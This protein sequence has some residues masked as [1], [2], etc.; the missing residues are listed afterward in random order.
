MKTGSDYLGRLRYPA[1][2]WSAAAGPLGDHGP[3]RGV[4][5]LIPTYTSTEGDRTACLRQCLDSV[6]TAPRPDHQPI[7]F[8]VVDNGLSP[9][10]ARQVAEML[11]GSGCAHRVVQAVSARSGRYTAAEAR[12]AGLAMLAELPDTSDLRQRHLLFLDDDTALEQHA[13]ARLTAV[14][15]AEQAAIA[16]C[17]RVVPVADLAAWRAAHVKGRHCAGE[18]PSAWAARQLPGPLSDAGYDLLSVIA[19]GSLITGRTVGLLV[20]QDPVM[21]WIG[22]HGP[23]FYTGTPYGSCEDILAMATLSRL[24]Q[25]WSVPAATVADEARKSPGATRR[26]QF[27]WGYDH[28]WLARRLAQA[29]LLGDGVRALSWTAQSACPTAGWEFGHADW[30]GPIGCL[31]NPG[32]LRFGYQLLQAVISSPRVATQLFG[33]QAEAV[34]A[35]TAQLGRVLDRWDSS[36]EAARQQPRPDLPPLGNRDWSSLRDGLDALIGHLA[37]NVAGSWGNGVG[38]A[39][40]PPF[41]LYGTRQPAADLGRPC[42]GG[43]RK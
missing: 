42:P 3:N 28:A 6:L 38:A 30:G 11:R 41:F 18:G 34:S 32:E 16:A 7:A 29:G 25:L 22:R 19:Y 37:G 8:V 36:R 20:R 26:Q 12:N 5:V 43:R 10:A 31:V 4:T 40:I 35:G 15:R 24:G 13:L 1:E 27:A 2:D 14:L 23:L 9:A 21:R 39:G 17:P 33:G